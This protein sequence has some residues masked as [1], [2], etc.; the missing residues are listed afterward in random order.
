MLFLIMKNPFELVV[1]RTD[2]LMVDE[3]ELKEASEKI[4]EKIDNKKLIVIEG[5]YGSGKS[6]YLKRLYERL[7]T[8]KQLFSFNEAIVVALETK[9]PVKKKTL[10]I[11]SFDLMQGLSDDRLFRLTNAMLELLKKDMMIL[12]TC[13]SD[14][15][16]K[17]Y[18]INPLLRS[19]T[20]RI[21]IPKMTYEDARKLVI[22]RLNE[23]R[24][25]KQDSLSPFSDKEL[26]KVWRK[27]KG[28]PR[29][30]LLLL[31]PL[32]EQ[33]MMIRE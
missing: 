25:E 33:R 9:V 17:L 28:N 1:P 27:S 10:F 14:T 30:L 16:K 11:K 12:I 5:D 29:L 3:K 23:A 19:R 7:K 13:R 8:K 24:K 21:R 31:R 4:K 26:K 32:Y 18:K 6:L 2:E 22:N 20:N 15:L